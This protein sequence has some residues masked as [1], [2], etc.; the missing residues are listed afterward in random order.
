M[1]G[2]AT[3]SETIRS[4]LFIISP[5]PSLSAVF[6]EKSLYLWFDAKPPFSIAILVQVQQVLLNEGSNISTVNP[7][8]AME[9]GSHA[10]SKNA[11]CCSLD[12]VRAAKIH[13]ANFEAEIQFKSCNDASLK[14]STRQFF[15][16][17]RLTER[18]QRGLL[19]LFK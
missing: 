8:L 13:V 14:R 17:G 10:H 1:K 4:S 11:R 6:T 12:Q 7:T 2:G 5:L 16:S 15:L 3:T 18:R 9:Y 19:Q